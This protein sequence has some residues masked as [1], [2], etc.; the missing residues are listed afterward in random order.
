MG[1]RAIGIGGGDFPLAQHSAARVLPAIEN[2]EKTVGFEAGMKGHAQET[3]LRGDMRLAVFDVEKILRAGSILTL[4]DKKDASV[5]F[6]DGEAIRTVR[7]L[8][9]PHEI[10]AHQLRENRTEQDF[11]QGLS[12]DG[13]SREDEREDN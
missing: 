9:H 1:V 12:L 3:L 4:A 2:V 13:M 7:R 10:A 11:G 8:F 5:L 6:H